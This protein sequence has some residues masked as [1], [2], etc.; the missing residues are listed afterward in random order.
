MILRTRQDR[1]RITKLEEELAMLRRHLDAA[2]ADNA[3]LKGEGLKFSDRDPGA[4]RCRLKEMEDDRN[5]W[6]ELAYGWKV[7]TQKGLK[8]QFEASK[9]MLQ[10]REKH[11]V[12]AAYVARITAAARELLHADEVDDP[13]DV[14]SIH[15]RMNDALMSAP[16]TGTT[17]LAGMVANDTMIDITRLREERDA[18]TA[19]VERLEGLLERAQKER[20]PDYCE[21]D[22]AIDKVVDD[23]PAT[24]LARRDARMKADG[25]KE[26]LDHAESKDCKQLTVAAGRVWENRFRK[27]AEDSQ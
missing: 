6:K 27:Q 18:L 9:V 8:T 21:L 16:S 2:R 15:S 7:E 4:L 11:D 14:A 22:E 26:M 13:E 5:R 23:S 1:A 17:T 24:S 10:L 19:H 12:L 3:R 20:I 25:L